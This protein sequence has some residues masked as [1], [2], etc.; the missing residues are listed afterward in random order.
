MRFN[1]RVQTPAIKQNAFGDCDADRYDLETLNT[2]DN[3]LVQGPPR[4]ILFVKTPLV[5]GKTLFT[6]T[7]AG[8]N[9]TGTI[10][11]LCVH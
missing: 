7:F 10:V 4:R 5:F 6:L 3:V 11:I 2:T 8:E 9:R 1:T